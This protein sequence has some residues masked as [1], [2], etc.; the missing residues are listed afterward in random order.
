MLREL[1]MMLQG[2]VLAVKPLPTGRCHQ[3]GSA[4]GASLAAT[5]SLAAW[6]RSAL[7]MMYGLYWSC[8]SSLA[9]AFTTCVYRSKVSGMQV[10]ISPAKRRYRTFKLA[11]AAFNS[12]SAQEAVK[13][14]VF[15]L[16][17]MILWLRDVACSHT[18]SPDQLDVAMLRGVLRARGLTSSMRSARLAAGLVGQSA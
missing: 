3:A 15:E 1:Q 6:S 2:A 13:L 17:S 9:A 12:A 18:T 8:W 16:S 7:L 10:Y 4:C 14:P 11:M 5:S